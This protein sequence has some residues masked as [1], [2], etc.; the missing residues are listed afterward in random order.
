MPFSERAY[1]FLLRACPG[2]LRR[3]HEHE[4][5]DAFAQM[6]AAHRRDGR[7]LPRL[8]AW[9]LALADVASVALR[10][11]VTPP[12]SRIPSPPN[13][14]RRVTY[15]LHD[16][17][18]ALRTLWRQPLFTA[19]AALTVTLGIGAT[20]TI[21]SVANTL[22]LRAPT[23]VTASESLV[24][25]HRLG[26]DGSSFH[27]FGEPLFSH[28]QRADAGMVS[29]AATT[30][31]MAGLRAGET[32]APVSVTMTSASYFD[33]VGARP[34]LGRFFEAGEDDA[35]GAGL[36]AVISH[37]LWQTRFEGD[38]AVVGR[39]LELNG[40]AF[41]IVGVAQEGF[42]GHT[43]VLGTDL[44]IPLS[45][46]APLLGL[47]PAQAEQSGGL[48]LVGQ[49]A[50]DTDPLAVRDVVDRLAAQFHEREG[51]AD[52]WHGVEVRRYSPVL[53]MAHD[54][55]LAFFAALFAVTGV[56]LAMTSANVATM[57]LSRGAS[58]GREVGVRLALG[59]SRGRLVAQ[60]LTESLSLFLLGAGGGVLLTVWL[61][62]LARRVELPIPVPLDLAFAPDLGVLAFALAVA[63]ASGVLFGLSPALHAT[64]GNLAGALKE[65]AGSG[66][67]FRQRGRS[68]LVVAQVAGSVVLLVT[69]GLLARSLG[70][71]VAIDVGFEPDDVQAIELD[72]RLGNR[73]P[74]ETAAYFDRVLEVARDT[75]GVR[76]AALTDTPPLGFTNRQTV[77]ELPDRAPEPEVGLL[78]V[79][80]A[81]VSPGLPATLGIPLVAGRDFSGDDVRG[82]PP[83]VLINEHLV[84]RA[85][86]GE[87]AVGRR[88][89]IRGVEEPLEVVGVLR[90]YKVRSAS[91]ESALQLLVSAAQFP[92][93]D[94]T[95]LARLDD[96]AT[97]AVLRDRIHELDLGLPPPQPLAYERM[98]GL[99]LLPGRIAAT[100]ASIFGGVGVLLAAVGLYGILAFGVQ[101]RARE[102][103]IRTAL[104][105]EARQLRSMVVRQALR[106][107]VLGV[108]LGVALAAGVAS[109]LR[110][111]LSGISPL[112]PLTYGSI[113]LLLLVVAT[114][115]SW[116]PAHRAA[117]TDPVDVLRAE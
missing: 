62:S 6:V 72:T 109:L 74:A 87:G 82:A 115:A 90:N 89:R 103:G 76:A 54:G 2:A 91:E 38:A 95:L 50:G 84:Q 3:T 46:R 25:L 68:L 88:L 29:V 48:E 4:M 116:L 5:V 28:L 7:P 27:A 110:G 40:T 63:C 105:A 99:A 15:L 94:T 85:W 19:V 31:I 14:D 42:R 67:A 21:F 44:W 20:T 41:T 108:L 107:T 77:I 1:R 10:R 55:V 8:R 104:G 81:R 43:V 23:G 66:T 97:V 32:V 13:E 111:M 57:L 113:G 30:T 49:L 79:E 9:M 114:V 86:P 106:L 39:S 12:D 59:A 69:A 98:I 56:L 93:P 65:G 70:R 61:T 18:F 11:R 58:R 73:T 16:L 64:R 35:P 24:T 101:Q 26:D 80:F 52:T 60:L 34:A 53:P 117:S 92:E 96:P 51:R 71:A 75:P 100:L 36:L 47:P 112:D 45:A 22:L 78:R 83:V 102:L 17:R 37:R 33:T